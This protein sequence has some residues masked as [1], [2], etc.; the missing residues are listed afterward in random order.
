MSA[1]KAPTE[2]VFTN[3]ELL[4]LIRYGDPIKN[5]S[6]SIRALPH[7]ELAKFAML[8]L[9]RLGKHLRP[10]LPDTMEHAL[11]QFITGINYGLAEYETVSFDALTTNM[12]MGN[13]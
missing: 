5:C 1:T 8:M 2:P 7:E 4:S 10:E 13:A 6:E 12:P 11:I 9:F 3:P